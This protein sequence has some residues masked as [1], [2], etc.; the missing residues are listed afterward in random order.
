[1]FDELNTVLLGISRDDL[2]SHDS[3]AAKHDLNIPLLADTSGQACE[4]YDVWRRRE[5]SGDM[6]IE[7][8]TFIID[9]DGKLAHILRQVDPVAH[10]QEVAAF[11]SDNL[12]P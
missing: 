7:R 10:I 8:S 6:G 3:F 9:A 5:T 11:I 4:A 1:M 12:R 2:T